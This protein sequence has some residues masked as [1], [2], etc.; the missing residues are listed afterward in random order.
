MK[1]TILLSIIFLFLVQLLFSTIP[2][3]IRSRFVLGDP[4]WKELLVKKDLAED[5]DRS[6]NKLVEIIVDNGYD[7]GFMEKDSGYL[8]TNPNI[9]IVILK[10]YWLYNK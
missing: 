2:K 3:S 5:Y 1:K 4:V 7:I 9:G 6:W 10:K 8:R